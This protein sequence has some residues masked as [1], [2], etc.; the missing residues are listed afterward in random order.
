MTGLRQTF[1]TVSEDQA[2]QLSQP[3][4]QYTVEVQP[5]RHQKLPA[6]AE[7]FI[8]GIQEYR[9]KWLKLVNTSP[10]IGFEIRRPEPDTVRLQFSVSSKPLERKIRS[11]LLN[12]TPEIGFNTGVNGL[13]VVEDDSIG[14]A[15]LSPGKPDWYPFRTKFDS[16]PLNAVISSL[17]R[18]SIPRTRIVI[19]ILFQ[20]VI[21]QP[22]HRKWW[23]RNAYQDARYLRKDKNRSASSRERNL[24]DLIEAKASNNRFHTAIRI[25]VIGAED[26]TASRVKEVSAG[27]NLFETG[28]TGQFF[29]VDTLNTFRE[30]R[31]LRFCQAVADRKMTGE[32]QLSVPELAALTAI[33][34]RKQSNINYAQQ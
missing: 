8:R 6:T 28:E 14:G 24:A 9:S 15:V 30:S 21:G 12:Q 19:Q 31:I 1:L 26:Y 16:P 32:F 18:H 10:V 3:P 5:P 13:P 29:K 11:Q 27:F 17:H 25:V 20:P 33:P 4:K 23:R 22:F 2:K 7:D 34:D